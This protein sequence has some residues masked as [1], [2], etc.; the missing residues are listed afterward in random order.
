MKFMSWYDTIFKE[1]ITKCCK[2]NN[3]RKEQYCYGDNYE[4]F[5][6]FK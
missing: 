5:Y 6:L 3:E 1:K 2:E 4:S